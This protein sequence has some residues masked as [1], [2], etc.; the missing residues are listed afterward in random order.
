MKKVKFK[1]EGLSK[2]ICLIKDREI[3]CPVSPTPHLCGES[4][5]WFDVEICERN[6]SAGLTEVKFVVCKG[7][8]VAELVEEE[9]IK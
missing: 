1:D 7:V 2:Y 9:E 4:C 8:R 3:Y 5:V 6:P